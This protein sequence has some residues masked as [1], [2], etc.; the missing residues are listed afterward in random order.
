M[1]KK[2]KSKLTPRQRAIRDCDNALSDYVRH[3]DTMLV[4]YVD[5]RPKRVGVCISCGKPT[6]YEQMDA[7]HFVGRG[8]YLLRWDIHNVN[9]QCRACNRFNAQKMWPLYERNLRAKFGDDEVDRLKR[10]AGGYAGWTVEE[11]HELRNS[12]I[13][14][15]ETANLEVTLR[16]HE[17]RNPLIELLSN[18]KERRN[19][20]LEH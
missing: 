8:D 14:A 19:E 13:E 20:N 11:L 18:I 5:G 12:L 16:L 10:E 3:R 9:G 17:L 15:T 4:G 7:G 2:R 1:R 6:N